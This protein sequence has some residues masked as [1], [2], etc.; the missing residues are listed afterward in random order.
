LRIVE[1]FLQARGKGHCESAPDAACGSEL[2][3][4]IA[5]KLSGEQAKIIEAPACHRGRAP[6]LDLRRL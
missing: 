3:R 2:E 6:Q 5:A 1:G 4:Q